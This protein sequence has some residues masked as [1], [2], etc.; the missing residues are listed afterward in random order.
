MATGVVWSMALSRKSKKEKEGQCCDG[1]PVFLFFFFQFDTLTHRSMEN[2]FE[3]LH[4][5]VRPWKDP[6]IHAQKSAS[7]VISNS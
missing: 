2:T 3:G 5:S 1:F 4:S 6:Q 7:Y